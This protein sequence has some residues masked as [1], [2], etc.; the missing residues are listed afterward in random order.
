[1]E[2]RTLHLTGLARNEATWYY[3][4]ASH[5]PSGEMYISR[6]TSV[7]NERMMNCMLGFHSSLNAVNGSHRSKTIAKS[8]GYPIQQLLGETSYGVLHRLH[9]KSLQAT[10]LPGQYTHCPPKNRLFLT[11]KYR[12]LCHRGE[13]KSWAECKSRKAQAQATRWFIQDNLPSD[14]KIP[15]KTV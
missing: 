6:N 3:S 4:S 9:N 15:R 12:F 2:V 10:T 11:L 8:R 7:I 1:M 14:S 5:F 13:G